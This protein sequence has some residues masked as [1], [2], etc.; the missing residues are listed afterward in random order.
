MQRLKKFSFFLNVKK[1]K[2]IQLQK[3]VDNG[4]HEFLVSRLS[5]MAAGELEQVLGITTKIVLEDR[6]DNC[7]CPFAAADGVLQAGP[8]Y[9]AIKTHGI[10]QSLLLLAWSNC[11]PPS[12]PVLCLAFDPRKNP[13]PS[14]PE[15]EINCRR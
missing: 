5:R 8:V 9:K 10:S 12:G 6:P 11:A 7:I 15:E 4:L 3:V 13:V 14:K 2:E 1:K